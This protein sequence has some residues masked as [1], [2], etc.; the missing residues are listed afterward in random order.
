MAKADRSHAE[1]RV[2][3]TLVR[4]F[5]ASPTL[6]EAGRCDGMAFVRDPDAPMPDLRPLRAH[7]VRMDRGSLASD[8]PAELL[9]VLF[10]AG[11][12]VDATRWP[13]GLPLLRAGTALV[14]FVDATTP[15]RP[16]AAAPQRVS[17]WWNGRRHGIALSALT[18]VPLADL[19][20]L[21]TLAI[22]RQLPRAVAPSGVPVTGRPLDGEGE[23]VVERAGAPVERSRSLFSDM[24]RALDAGNRGTP[25]S[26]LVRGLFG[27]RTIGGSGASGGEGFSAPPPPRLLEGIMGWLRW[28]TPLG[29][30]LR[31]AFSQRINQVEK[32]IQRGDIDAALRLALRLGRNDGQHKPKSRF[33]ASLPSARARLD[34]TIGDDSYSSPLLGGSDFFAISYRYRELA[35]QLEKQGDHRRAAYIHSQLLSDHRRAVEVLEAGGLFAEAARLSLDSHQEAAMS[36]RLLYKSG[37]R[38]AALALARRTGCFE[39]LA[40]DSRGKDPEYHAYVIK[41]WTDMLL[42][43]GQPLR[44][45]QVT[46][47]LAADTDP[48]RA[49]I[50]TRRQWLAAALQVEGHEGFGG[51]LAARGLL[52]ARWGDDL[53]VDGIGAFPAMPRVEGNAP[54]PALIEWLQTLLRGESEEAR[55]ILLEL[56]A[57]LVRLANAR[58]AEQQRFWEGPA[59][60]VLEAFARALLAQA[61]DGLT[62][63]DLDALQRMLRFADQRVL[64]ADIEKLRKLHVATRNDGNWPVPPPDGDRPVA[65]CA[66][67]LA[68]GNLLVWRESGQLQLLDR[69]GALLHQANLRD[70]VALVPV[71]TSPN[72]LIVQSQRDGSRLLTRF[73]SHARAFHPIGRVALVAHHDITT[74]GE[75]LVQIGGEIGAL[76]L[77]K[78]CAASPTVSFLW[79]CALTDRLRAIAFAHWKGRASWLTCDHGRARAGI[80]ELW[81]LHQNGKLDTSICLPDSDTPMLRHW[82]WHGENGEH[83]RALG[84]LRTRMRI[85]HWTEDHEAQAHRWVRAAAQA[86]ADTLDVFQPC[87]LGRPQVESMPIGLMDHRNPGTAIGKPGNASPQIFLRHDRDFVL[88]CL[89]RRDTVLLGDPHGRLFLVDPERG[90]VT[91]L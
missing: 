35:E 34:F 49:L 40:D 90:R 84:Q 4:E 67:L 37:E 62:R 23:A 46:D 85:L 59:P 65:R 26:D 86:G 19:W 45:L 13:A 66:C 76:D 75:W 78:L 57:A 42:A 27:R 32:L 31:G 56:M 77:A 30:G 82:I 1:R 48:D 17:L 80:V 51:E 54:W 12:A 36:I 53:A 73:A 68:G 25:L 2:A 39:Q 81:S 14:S 52:A 28:H 50:A 43:T 83:M 22:H 3:R 41:A 79:S 6:V 63:A 70:V 61:S 44:A 18:P 20:D 9:V 7:I 60:V 15:P 38:D 71:G 33:P 69:H 58:H 21:P 11:V 47:A 87:D 88:T 10:D 55:R 29:N 64:A 16:A 72:V 74:E 89:A 24:T 5:P 8:A 91:L